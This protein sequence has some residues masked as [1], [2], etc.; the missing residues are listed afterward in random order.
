MN[1]RKKL[2]L[3]EQANKPL[4]RQL[5]KER[6]LKKRLK[7]RAKQKTCL[8]DRYWFPHRYQYSKCLPWDIWDKI[9]LELGFTVKQENGKC[10]F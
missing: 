10:N 3:L 6:K 2:Y 8:C 5:V 7:H 4:Q 1:L 9:S